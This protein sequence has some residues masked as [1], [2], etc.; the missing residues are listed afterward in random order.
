MPARDDTQRKAKGTDKRKATAKDT[1]TSKGKVSKP[2]TTTEAH[3]AATSELA[4]DAGTGGD[5]LV[6]VMREAGVEVAF[7]VVSIHNQP[8][9]EAIDR[10][11]RFVPV[12]HEASAVNAADGYARATGGIGVAIASTG[13]GAGNAA[14]SMLEALTAESR[15]LHV[16][17]NINVDL[18]GEGKGAYHE[19]PR[20]LAMLQAVSAHAIR[21]Q[22]ARQARRC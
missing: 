4:T 21:I 1:R 19:V 10:E 6:E 7:G 17:G 9:V 12:R 2:H 16:T 14:G 8:L 3:R 15:V 5:I 13:T 22:T 18:I 11:L 20:Q